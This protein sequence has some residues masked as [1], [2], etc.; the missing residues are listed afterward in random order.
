MM[1][2]AISIGAYLGLIL[3]QIIWH[4]LL[5]ASANR[6][7][8]TLAFILPLLP[9]L[10]LILAR[11]KLAITF[12]GMVVLFYFVHAVMETMTGTAPLW[13]AQMQAVLSILFI[14]GIALHMRLNPK[15]R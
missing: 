5:S 11:Y 3:L 12:A 2:R 15:R 4:G 7:H 1:G 6:W 8:V 13:P 10:V 14:A 9:G